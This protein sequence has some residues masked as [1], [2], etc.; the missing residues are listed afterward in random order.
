MSIAGEVKE[1]PAGSVGDVFTRA[2]FVPLGRGGVT[3]VCSSKGRWIAGYCDST[4]SGAAGVVVNSECGGFKAGEGAEGVV[5]GPSADVGAARP[6]A[7]TIA[8]VADGLVGDIVAGSRD[9]VSEVDPWRGVGIVGTS[10]GSAVTGAAGDNA[11]TVSA[12][13]AAA[14]AFL[15]IF[16]RG[17][18]VVRLPLFLDWEGSAVAV[19]ASVDTF[20]EDSAVSVDVGLAFALV[21]F[22]LFEA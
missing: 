11:V 13:A 22:L 6:A 20:V 18:G 9:G 16:L 3:V 8:I 14:R 12:V 10:N 4:A 2:V 17:A 1:G 7:A 21:F 19:W 15:V 5:V